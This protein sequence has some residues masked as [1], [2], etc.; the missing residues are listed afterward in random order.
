M[1]SLRV[2]LSAVNREM[3]RIVQKQVPFALALALNDTVEDVD[4]AW[5]EDLERDL[6]NPTPFTKKGTFK[7]RASKRR[8]MGQVGFK[9]IQSQYLALQV[10]G[11]VRKPKGRAL[12]VPAGIR[13]NKYGNITRGAVAK[14][15]QK[16]TTFV[17]SS[18]DPKT[19][20]LKPGIY[21]RPKRGRYR[22][23]G[24]GRKNRGKVKGPKMLISFKSKASYR[25]RLDLNGTASAKV[26]EVF[27]N[28][29][30]LRFRA[31]VATAK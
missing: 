18:S 10:D 17:A 24:S 12:I 29:F 23:G 28:H 5:K 27:G 25:K 19:R 8:L 31:A 4:G 14:A 13:L 20:H 21:D 3:D 11:G 16:A 30:D 15:G 7:R 22:A 1:V 6:E 2:D 9:P 26:D